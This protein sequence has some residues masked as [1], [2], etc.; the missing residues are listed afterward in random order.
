[1]Q[2]CSQQVAPGTYEAAGKFCEDMAPL[3]LYQQDILEIPLQVPGHGGTEA[4]G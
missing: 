1:M 4:K 3:V 2:G